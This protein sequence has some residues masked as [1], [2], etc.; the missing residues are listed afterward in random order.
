MGRTLAHTLQMQCVFE[1]SRTGREWGLM[2][3]ELEGGTFNRSSHA[4]LEVRRSYVEEG[5]AASR[6]VVSAFIFLKFPP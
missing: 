3:A 6:G 2:M 4:A 5:A 1:R